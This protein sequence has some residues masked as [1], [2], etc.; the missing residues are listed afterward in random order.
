MSSLNH[1]KPNSTQPHPDKENAPFT[2]N[3]HLE[4][5][6]LLGQNIYRK[7]NEILSKPGLTHYGQEP[8]SSQTAN[9]QQAANNSHHNLPIKGYK[10]SSDLVKKLNAHRLKKTLVAER[11]SYN[12]RPGNN[13]LLVQKDRYSVAG[14]EGRMSVVER[15]ERYS[16]D[17][18][19]PNRSSFIETQRTQLLEPAR[20][21]F[22]EKE[23]MKLNPV[24]EPIVKQ[25]KQEEEIV[26]EK[27]S[28]FV[29][30]NEKKKTVVDKIDQKAQCDKILEEYAEEIMESLKLKDV[31]YIYNDPKFIFL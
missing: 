14:K 29:N 11:S 31:S 25:E 8:L 18:H 20:A 15:G 27:I 28:S 5:K 19:G 26:A 7:V 6:A 21:S 23:P 16:F 9:Q 3:M 13:N 1:I 22:A 4:K 12:G 2:S 24:L 17:G 30:E 10:E